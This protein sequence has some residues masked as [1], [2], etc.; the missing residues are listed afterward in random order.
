[1]TQ[2]ADLFLI[3]DL[4]NDLTELFSWSSKEQQL[5]EQKK[6]DKAI[7]RSQCGLKPKGE[8][9]KQLVEQAVDQPDTPMRVEQEQQQHNPGGI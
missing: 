6:I 7:R 9:K 1:M 3:Q 2:R 8:E 4:L 5:H